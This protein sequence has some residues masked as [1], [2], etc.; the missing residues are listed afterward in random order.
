MTRPRTRS[1]P[2]PDPRSIPLLVP[3]AVP[4]GSGPTPFQG[5]FGSVTGDGR[6]PTLRLPTGSARVGYSA[7]P[8]KRHRLCHARN[9]CCEVRPLKFLSGPVNTLDYERDPFIS[10]DDNTLGL[11][12]WVP[13]PHS[14]ERSSSPHA[15]A[16]PRVSAWKSAPIGINNPNLAS[17]DP[18]LMHLATGSTSGNPATSSRRTAS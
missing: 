17:E 2:P 8:A 4:L 9:H 6:K 16:P 3:R 15:P 18:F 7:D 10:R 14:Q 12:G 1:I 13:C 5:H 11:P